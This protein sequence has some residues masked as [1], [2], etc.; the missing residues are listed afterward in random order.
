MPLH[1]PCPAKAFDDIDALTPLGEPDRERRPTVPSPMMITSAGGAVTAA[2]PR[3]RRHQPMVGDRHR[4]FPA[5]ALEADY[6]VQSRSGG[7]LA[8]AYHLRASG[9]PSSGQEPGF[10]ISQGGEPPLTK[11]YRSVL[12]RHRNEVYTN[13]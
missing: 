11:L 12:T 7:R 9:A 2:H 6:T 8:V 5:L 4:S 1:M 3:A 13:P 10:R